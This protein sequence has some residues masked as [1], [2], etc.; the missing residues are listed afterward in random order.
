MPH[1]DDSPPAAVKNVKVKSA[2]AAEVEAQAVTWP[3]QFL[4]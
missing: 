2:A 3:E 4:R 1:P